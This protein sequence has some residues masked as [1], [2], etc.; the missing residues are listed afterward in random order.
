[1]MQRTDFFYDLPQ[2]LIAQTPIE[3]RDH[4]RLLKL[5]RAD[6]SLADGRFDD[7]LEALRPGDCLVLND[8]RV[9][10]ARLY[11]H[12]KGTGAAVELLLL[13]PQGN[14][15][16]EVLAG[17]G[18]RAKP[19]NV[20]SFGGGILNNGEGIRIIPEGYPAMLVIMPVGGFLVLGFVIAGSQALMTYLDKK[21]KMKEAA[22]K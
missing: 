2:E 5:S 11:G 8:S 10:P 14:D 16:W 20:I 15:T 4:S 19:G 7:I 6:G 12:R 13:N 21:N 1:M 3:P 18:R 17:P 9:L 22:K